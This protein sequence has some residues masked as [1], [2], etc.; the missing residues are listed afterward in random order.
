MGSSRGLSVLTLLYPV[1]APFI[2]VRRFIIT[3]Y[4]RWVLCV[5][6]PLVVDFVVIP[7]QNLLTG[8]DFYERKLGFTFVQS[9]SPESPKICFSDV[10]HVGVPDGMHLTYK[11][12]QYRWTCQGLPL[13]FASK[14][15]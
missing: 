12:G 7:V 14:S 6:M 8:R 1:Q 10:L 2:G 9:T 5:Q 3:F 15:H 11:D 13:V 4:L